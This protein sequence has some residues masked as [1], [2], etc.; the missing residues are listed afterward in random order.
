MN[1]NDK[2]VTVTRGTNIRNLGEWRGTLEQKLKFLTCTYRKNT[3]GKGIDHKGI[4]I[5]LPVLIEGQCSML[6]LGPYLCCG[7]MS[8]QTNIVLP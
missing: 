6:G 7:Y 4:W 3:M 2:D 5:I 1:N 8:H